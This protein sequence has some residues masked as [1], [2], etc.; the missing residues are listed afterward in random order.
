MHSVMCLRHMGKPGYKDDVSLNQ[1]SFADEVVG[2]V[3]DTEVTVASTTGE[4]IVIEAMAVEPNG[5]S[6]DGTPIINVN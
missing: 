2:D 4:T 1:M 6:E 5:F 3:S